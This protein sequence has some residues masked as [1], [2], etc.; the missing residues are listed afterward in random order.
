MEDGPNQLPGS[1]PQERLTLTAGKFGMMDWFD[2]NAYSHDPRSQFMNWNLANSGA[3][4]YPADTF[5]YTWG[6]VAEYRR[7][8]WAVRGAAVAEP[9]V[10]N[11]VK[12]DT[13]VGRAQGFAVEAERRSPWE[14]YKGTFR[15]LVFLNQAHMGNYDQAIAQAQAAGQ[16]PDVTQS[17]AYGHIK[18]GFTSSDD[19]QLTDAL[20]AFVRLSWSDGRNETWAYTEA[21]GSAAAGLDWTAAK[22]GRPGD[23]WGFAELADVL[24]NPHRRYLADGGL[25]FQLGDGGLHYGPEIITETYYSIR[26]KDWLMVSP[27][28]QLLVNPGYNRSRGPVP[29][30]GVRVH[31]EFRAA[32][33]GKALDS[34]KVCG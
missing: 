25:G 12:M 18:Y 29:V 8:A 33:S 22:F 16:A 30:W 5:G 15:F 4:D 23:H 24:S 3:W 27:D 14:D 31:A 20:G 10:A 11:E 1:V 17:R 34:E 7:P 13:R 32:D 6:M 26:L 28:G 9:E 21:D 2:S 19:L